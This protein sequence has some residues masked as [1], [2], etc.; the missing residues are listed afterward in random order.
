MVPLEKR[1]VVFRS[2]A[3]GDLAVVWIGFLQV[4]RRIWWVEL[5]SCFNQERKREREREIKLKKKR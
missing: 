2:A 4:A 3:M 5:V 1:V